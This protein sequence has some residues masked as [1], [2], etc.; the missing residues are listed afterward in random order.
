MTL[1]DF[2]TA[3]AITKR[4][5][6]SPETYGADASTMPHVRVAREA[7]RAAGK[8]IYDKG[9]YVSYVIYEGSDPTYPTATLAMDPDSENTEGKAVDVRWYLEKQIL[10][11]F[12]RLSA[13][14]PDLCAAAPPGFLATALGMD[15]AVPPPQTH[16]RTA[17]AAALSHTTQR[18]DLD[19]MLRQECASFTNPVL[20][21]SCG[22]CHEKIDALDICTRC[23]SESHITER[24][25]CPLFGPFVGAA[26]S[27]TKGDLH[28]SAVLFQY[29]LLTTLRACLQ[30]DRPKLANVLRE[31]VVHEAPSEIGG[32]PPPSLS[33]FSSLSTP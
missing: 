5:K 23:G 28:L 22:Q 3:F 13:S 12:E 29:F 4:L 26:F 17:T 10:P 25:L 14:W 15:A 2:V 30:N 21:I 27:A 18:S 31:I 11:V 33:P 7:N 6:R 1:A 8:K 20:T 32:L 19:E 9:D 24:V 16:K